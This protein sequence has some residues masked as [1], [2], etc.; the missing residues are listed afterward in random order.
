M[1]FR[2][3]RN[4]QPSRT[5][6]RQS[7]RHEH[8]QSQTDQRADQAHHHD[9]HQG[10]RE[11]LRAGRAQGFHDGKGFAPPLDKAGGGIGHTD[12]ADHQSRQSDKREKLREALQIATKLR[13]GIATRAHFKGCIGKA[14]VDLGG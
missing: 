5:K 8:A 12:A 6:A 9:F 11:G 4:G 14:L 13:G 10:Q 3:Q 2:L 1:K 7:P